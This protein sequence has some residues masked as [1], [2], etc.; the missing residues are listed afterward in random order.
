M[1]RIIAV[2]DVSN[3]ISK[4]VKSSSELKFDLF[5]AC[6]QK[7]RVDPLKAQKFL[8]IINGSLQKYSSIIEESVQKS[9]D[10]KIPEGTKGKYGIRYLDVKPY[11]YVD[12]D[13]ASVLKFTEGLYDGV[14]TGKI[15]I[16]I[17][18]NQVN[19]FFDHTVS[20]AYKGMPESIG[21][22]VDVIKSI[23]TREL[24]DGEFKQFNAV[25][26]Q[27]IY[28]SN[29]RKEVYE[30][31][32][33]V[34]D[35]LCD[36][37]NANHDLSLGKDDKGLTS[38][39]IGSVLEYIS[40]SIALFIVRAY[41]I[42]EYEK[43]F[44]QKTINDTE[45]V[46]ESDGPVSES[47][48]PLNKI[49]DKRVEFINK[50]DLGA[51][52]E[53]KDYKKLFVNIDEAVSILGGSLTFGTQ[54]D[55]DF[56]ACVYR[57]KMPEGNKIAE[58]MVGNG[59]YEFLTSNM[60]YW[61]D[62]NIIKKYADCADD[63]DRLMHNGNIALSTS[64]S[65]RQEF[66]NVLKNTCNPPAAKDIPELASDLASFILTITHNLVFLNN[67]IIEARSQESNDP[68]GNY[69]VLNNMARIAKNIK[70][71][72][73][74]LV[75]ILLSRLTDMENI[76][77]V[78]KE[79]D[80]ANIMT[81]LT[82]KV[83][84]NVPEVSD[85]HELDINSIVPDTARFAEGVYAFPEYEVLQMYSEY[86][87]YVLGDEYIT[88]AV[89]FSKIMD[90]FLAT[91]TTWFRKM[92]QFIDNPRLKQVIKWVNENKGKLQSYNYSGPIEVLPYKNDISYSM[93][94]KF[95]NVINSFSDG[96]IKDDDSL[97]KYIDSLYDTGDATLTGI[98]KGENKKDVLQ[99]Y[100]LFGVA[101]GGTV[102]TKTLNTDAEIKQAMQ[103]WISTVS[104][105]DK[106][107]Q[108][109]MTG[110]QKST[111]AIKGLKSKLASMKINTTQTDAS[112]NPTDNSDPQMQARLQSCITRV[113]QA[114]TKVIF[115]MYDIFHRAIFDQYNYIKT[116]YSKKTS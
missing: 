43:P 54:L 88:E 15:D 67:N 69:T 16:T 87:N 51:I 31:S 62:R 94:D 33:R 63:F 26:S 74:E 27:T 14:R 93:I 64:I 42:Y 3:D 112:G 23:D 56:F 104:D 4:L 45:D 98:I 76:I 8:A 113:Q 25:K 53:P 68:R 90:A 10:Y 35:F 65:S 50:V 13:Y 46:V 5:R 18:R 101:P 39:V 58:E 110:E 80:L 97:D 9:K 52:H 41:I 108:Q 91:V 85:K 73:G 103:T 95:A 6:Y 19:E 102:A 59:L 22:L 78:G 7:R 107:R 32:R 61:P 92:V 17:D 96:N 82:I 21:G 77:N 111:A 79:N 70:E 29:E 81:Q 1:D 89:D 105:C 28:R 100:V 114:Y 11:L 37:I 49:S 2:T 106:F 57:E 44:I 38:A 75:E 71:L 115:P 86:V 84:A 66:I 109:I 99:N 40:Y 83:P 116:A 34:I 30:S 48:D 36:D 55:N 60:E 47:V 72:Y 24:D 12:F 20:L